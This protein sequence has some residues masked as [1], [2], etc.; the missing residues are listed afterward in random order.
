MRT[1]PHP[2]LIPDYVLGSHNIR[3]SYAVVYMMMTFWSTHSRRGSDYD[4]GECVNSEG[5]RAFENMCQYQE[6]HPNVIQEMILPM[7]QLFQSC[8]LCH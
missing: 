8:I 6:N 7:C 3:V 5:H 1:V 2:L 4:G